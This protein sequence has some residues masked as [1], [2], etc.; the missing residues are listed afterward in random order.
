MD[1]IKT[2]TTAEFLARGGKITKADSHQSGI[3]KIP[4]VTKALLAKLPKA[5]IK[6]LELK[7]GK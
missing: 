7:H 5:L 2:E 1:N 4:L 6:K 3:K